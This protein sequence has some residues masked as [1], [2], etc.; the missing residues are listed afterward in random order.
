VNRLNL[1]ALVAFL[2]IAALHYSTIPKTIWEYDE[3]L[4][5]LGV[6][7]YQPLVHYPPPPG[8]PIY[9]GFAKV[10]ALFTGGD[11]FRAL[12]IA[13][14]ITLAAGLMAWYFAFR[15]ITGEP[16]IAIF[17]A[18][19]L[20]VSPALLISGVLPQSDSGALALFGLAA[21]ACAKKSPQFAAVACAACV[22]WRQQ[23]AVAIVPMLLV[24]LVFFKG[25][26][27]RVRAIA[28]F[29]VTCLIWLMPLIIATNGP[30]GFWKW[31]SGQAAYYASHDA[32]LSRSG[33]STSLLLFRFFAHPWGPKWLALPLLAIAAIGAL[34]LVA[35]KNKLALPLAT[36]CILYLGFALATMDPADAVRY[37]IPS[38]PAIA[39]FAAVPLMKLA[40]IGFLVVATYAAGAV[41]YTLPVLRAR[42]TSDAPSYAAA[43]WIRG[44]VPKN[45]IVLYDL[46]LRPHAENLLREWKSMRADAGLAKFGGDPNVPMVLYADGARGALPGVTF[47]WPDTDAYR[48]LTRQHYGAVSVIALPATGRYRALYGINSPERTREGASWRWIAERG[49]IE[50]PDLGKSNVRLTFHAPG[51]YPLGENRIRVR[52][53]GRELAITVQTNS[54][55]QLT[56]PIPPGITRIEIEPEKSFVPAQVAGAMNRDT[57]RLSVMLTNVEQF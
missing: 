12:I 13:S 49:V 11:A 28:T 55:A 4:F 52:V 32:D 19:L 21:Y 1:L 30:V 29:G 5:A 51:D 20:Y 9:M 3:Q 8:Y 14:V 33:Y 35:R 23:F 17:G 7:D 31:L 40:L 39:L 24:S 43:K 44:H 57:R 47:A 50:L 26:R 36:G 56:I 48:K 15:E 54:D 34:M 6:E 18:M 22:G 10:I 37:A 27:D 46:P 53:H 38:L 25:W 42:A 16:S 2:G 41:D 45:T